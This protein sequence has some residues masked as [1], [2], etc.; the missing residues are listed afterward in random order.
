LC[1]PLPLDPSL[2]RDAYLGASRSKKWPIY[3]QGTRDAGERWIRVVAASKEKWVL[4][5]KK[6]L[7]VYPI[8]FVL[9]EISLH[10]VAD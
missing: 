1:P 4:K 6:N 10:V 5:E 3:L 7:S 8:V 9:T 2:L